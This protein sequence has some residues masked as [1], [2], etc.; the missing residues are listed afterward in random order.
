MKIKER[1]TKENK[2][3]RRKRN[4]DRKKYVC[5]VGCV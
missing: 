4:K 1:K 3:S 5:S 2:E